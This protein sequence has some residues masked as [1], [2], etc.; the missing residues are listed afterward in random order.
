MAVRT[1]DFALVHL[2]ENV[3]PPP[4]REVPGN[5][6]GFLALLINV[7]ELEND[8]VGLS[9]VDTRMPREVLEEKQGA[10]NTTQLFLTSGL[11]DVPSLV[12]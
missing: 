9:A 1:D 3:L 12:S 7:V 10:L 5:L 8:R 2:V 4:L 6:E 11:P